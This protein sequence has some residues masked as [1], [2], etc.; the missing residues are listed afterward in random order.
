MDDKEK[1]AMRNQDGYDKMDDEGKEEYDTKM[2]KCG[3]KKSEDL[4]ED[5]LQK[6]LDALEEFNKSE[7]TESRKDALLKKAQVSELEK[8]EQDELYELLGGGEPKDE[9]TLSDEI[10]KS[11]EDNEDLQKALDV[12]DYLRENT[13]EMVKSM[14]LI[15]DRQDSSD[16]RQHAYNLILAKAVAKIGELT[17]SMADKLEIVGNQPSRG[18]KSKGVAAPL[19]KSFGGDR[20]QGESLSKAQVLDIMED[21]IVKSANSGGGGAV[22]GIDM[23]N[24]ASQYEQMNTM[25]PTVKGLVMRH[26][27]ANAN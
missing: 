23:V 27:S 20:P 21:M 4:T 22:E 9:L 8:S 13:E 12:S 6:S 18:P 2:E 25:S 5:D 14:K 3:W 17:K 19:E 11:M 24:A 1:D 26:R 16:T 10:E 7:D 15:A